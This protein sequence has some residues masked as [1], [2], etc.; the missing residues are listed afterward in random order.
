M[1]RRFAVGFF[2]AAVLAAVASG[3]GGGGGGDSTSSVATTPV[4]RTKAEYVSQVNAACREKKAGLGK[5]IA[6]YEQ[7]LEGRT[8][9]RGADMIHFVYLPMI[10]EQITAIQRVT[11]PPSQAGYVNAMLDADGVALDSLAVKP[12][13]PSIAVAEKQFANSNRLFW[14]YGLNSCATRPKR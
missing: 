3:C 1:N 10:E 6:E 8:P 12:R 2:C 4:P 14:A 9:A 7:R 11:P 5:E 13:V